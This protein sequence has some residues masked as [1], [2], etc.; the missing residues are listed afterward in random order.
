MKSIITSASFHSRSSPRNYLLIITHQK[1]D[2]L[3]WVS[4]F[5]KLLIEAGTAVAHYRT[6]YFNTGW[7]ERA[8]GGR[9]LGGQKK[10][11]EKTKP[12]PSMITSA[13]IDFDQ[14]KPRG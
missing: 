8:G 3:K 13:D 9:N 5:V 14:D 7:R 12:E 11:D 1:N 10:P 4:I 2:Q 6:E